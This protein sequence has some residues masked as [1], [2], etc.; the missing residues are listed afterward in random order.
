MNKRQRKMK[1]KVFLME[2]VSARKVWQ[3]RP[4]TFIKFRVKVPPGKGNGSDTI[5]TYGWSKANWPDVWDA[6]YGIELAED[7]AFARAVRIIMEKWG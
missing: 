3:E 5:E 6:E 2:N 7:K 1:L 4:N